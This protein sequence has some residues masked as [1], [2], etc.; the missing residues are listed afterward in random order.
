MPPTIT[1]TADDFRFGRVLPPPQTGEWSVHWRL[2]RNCSLAP[3]QLLNFYFGVCLVSLGIAAGFWLHGATLVLPFAWLEVLALGLAVLAYA[4]H[5]GDAENIRLQRDSLTVECACGR[6][7]E[8]VEFRPD[9]VR[10]EPRDGD[11]SLIELS[12]QGRRIVIGRFVRPELRRQ[13]ADELRRALRSG[14]GVA[15]ASR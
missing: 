4:V 15:D 8:R 1:S 7:T 9:R 10:V 2:K 5:A 12:S 14:P 11:G 13:L 3:R 6:R